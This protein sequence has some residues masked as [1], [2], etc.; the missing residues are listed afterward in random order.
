MTAQTP[1]KKSN[2]VTIRRRGGLE[3]A[4]DPLRDL[5]RPQAEHGH[6]SCKSDVK[7]AVDESGDAI[8]QCSRKA[9][10]EIEVLLGCKEEEPAQ[11]AE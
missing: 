8:V 1:H 11:A 10:R 3:L 4:Q 6:I 7:T 2:L 9:R 5:P